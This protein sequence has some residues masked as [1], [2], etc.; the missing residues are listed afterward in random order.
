MRKNKKLMLSALATSIAIASVSAQAAPQAQ[1]NKV[2]NNDNATE[3]FA[4]WRAQ[5]KLNRQDYTD[6]LIITFKDKNQGK[7]FLLG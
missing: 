6:R 7:W 3:S 1:I 2:S 5:E 4:E